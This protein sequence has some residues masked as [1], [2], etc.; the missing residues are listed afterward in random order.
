LGIET[1]LVTCPNIDPLSD[2]ADITEIIGL[3]IEKG[4]VY[5]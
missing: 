3:K 1:S 5:E 2:I 4:S